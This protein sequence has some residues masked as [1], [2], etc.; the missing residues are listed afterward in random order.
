MKPLALFLTHSPPRPEISGDRIRTFHLMREL[1]DRGW[2]VS[3]FSLVAPSEPSGLDEV[4]A[5][6][7][8][9]WRVVA[10]QASRTRRIANLGA[11]LL[12]RRAFQQ[13]WFW[14]RDAAHAC[15]AWLDASPAGPL[16]VEQLYMFPYV[17]KSLRGTVVLDT[18]NLEVA[19]MR[20]MATSDASLARRTIARLQVGPVARYEAEAVRSVARV[21]AVSHQ[22]Q[23]AFEKL[24]PGRVRLVPN[25]VDTR[26][27]APIENPPNSRRL[28]YMGSMSYGPNV[29]A[30]LHFLGE[31]GPLVR[32]AD[33]V[34]DV[35][36]SNPPASIYEASTRSRLKTT[37]AGYVADIG[38]V[39]RA[40]RAMVVPIRHGGG[41]RLK[42]L[43]ALAW[44]LPVIT[45]PVGC[46]GLGL[47]DGRE[48]LIADTREEF[49]AA[50]DKLLLDD[51]L[52]MGL[53]RAG[54]D[55]VERHFDWQ[56]I[57]ARFDQIMRELEAGS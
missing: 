27:I 32:S 21:L 26:R 10:R 37:V 52:W 24:T 8:D 28:L 3:L 55:Y 12:R 2:H 38:P 39:Y 48:A 56:A 19:R 57:G 34:L 4:L 25:G 54:R 1:R 41:T 31:I 50:I 49:A 51:D 22:E 42:I 7:A 40:S 35:V 23:S 17:P 47:T 33:T 30:V 46:A 9:E 16:F 20:A 11:G 44:G 43:E 29:D 53:S 5:D 36:G 45:T 13:D 14:S 18:Q 6:A 15:R